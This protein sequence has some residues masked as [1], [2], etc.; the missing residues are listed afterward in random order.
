MAKGS[1]NMLIAFD[2]RILQNL[3]RMQ[4]RAIMKNAV[5]GS[6]DYLPPCERLIKPYLGFSLICP[7]LHNIK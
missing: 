1:T 3:E 5:D 7:S 4:T 2:E 6:Y